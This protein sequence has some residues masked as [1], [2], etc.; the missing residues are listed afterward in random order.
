MAAVTVP[1]AHPE[2]RLRGAF[3]WR[4]AGRLPGL[5]LVAMG[6]LLATPATTVAE[7][8]RVAVATNFAE[9]IAEVA[10]HFKAATGHDLLVSTGAT[11]AL[12]AQ[13][14]AG[15]PFDVLLAA[16]D[17]RPQMLE[18]GGQGVAGTRFT[19][20]RGRLAL[21]SADPKRIGS[22]GV[23]CLQG[24]EFRALAI[25]DPAVAPYGQA[26]REVLQRLGLWAA[27]EARVVYGKN[28]GQTHALVATGNAEF[29][30]VAMSHVRSATGASGGS[31]WIVPEDLHAP[32]RQDAVLLA[33]ASDN[34]AARAFL[35]Y[36]RSAEAQALFERFGYGVER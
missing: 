25:A 12:F 27:L 5:L 9:P 3:S 30:L 32:I 8:V 35:S 10:R 14:K 34:T 26:A 4:S 21:W 29:G 6:V 18:E 23:A 36:L 20:A 15:A 13:I 24:Q 31:F 7:T 16:D 11:G 22:D 33:P 1:P 17:K 2:K 28:I 19:Y